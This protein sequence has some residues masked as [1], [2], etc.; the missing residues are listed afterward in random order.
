MFMLT[1]LNINHRHRLWV[2]M[3]TWTSQLLLYPL[4]Y[5][6]DHLALRSPATISGQRVC[7]DKYLEME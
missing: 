4:Q 3:D 2:L 6:V 5:L 1:Q 7:P